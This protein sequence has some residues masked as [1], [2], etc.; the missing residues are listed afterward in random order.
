MARFY[1]ADAPVPDWFRTDE[2]LLEPL[3]PRHTERDFAAVID[4]RA[5]LRRWSQSDWPAD[6]F[7]LEENRTDLQRQW[8]EHRQGESFAYTVMDRAGATCVGCVYVKPLFR[9]LENATHVIPP[10]EQVGDDLALINFWTRE[11]L[12]AGHMDRRMLQTLLDWLRSDV[13]AF[14]GVYV[15]T[16]AEMTRQIALCEELGL[17]LRYT[18]QVDH[19]VDWLVYG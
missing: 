6:D 7:T 18:L 8:E 15:G 19:P 4:S 13:W 17:T 2:F 5:L 16:N 11:P 9:W 3:H 1:P 10:A 12:L 14:Q